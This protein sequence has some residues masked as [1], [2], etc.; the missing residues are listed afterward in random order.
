MTYFG[1]SVTEI[2]TTQ[3]DYN[4]VLICVHCCQI[5]IYTESMPVYSLITMRGGS[6]TILAAVVTYLISQKVSK[7]S[8]FVQ[9]TIQF[10]LRTG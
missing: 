8:V 5:P 4:P 7:V 3:E 1:K 6:T 9:L 2:Y 10:M